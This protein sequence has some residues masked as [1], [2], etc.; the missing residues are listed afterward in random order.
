MPIATSCTDK[1]LEGEHVP[2]VFYVCAVCYVPCV[3][4]CNLMLLAL[5]G[6]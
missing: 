6:D 4:I 3:L 1:G 2:A 5:N